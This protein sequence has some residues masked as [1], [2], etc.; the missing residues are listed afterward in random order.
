VKNSWG[1]SWGDQGYINMGRTNSTNN[2]GVCGLATGAVYP[3]G[4]GSSIIV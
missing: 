2:P 3:T 4:N 1:T